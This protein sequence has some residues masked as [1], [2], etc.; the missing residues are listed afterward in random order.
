MR[1]YACIDLK[2]FY[3]SVECVER[4]WDPL[5]A[6]V[7][8]AD[9]ARTD[10][11]ICLAVS[12]ALKAY[13]ISSRARLF[14]AKQAVARANAARSV[15]APH[16]KLIG[17]ALD[18]GMLAADS[19][20]AIGFLAAPPRMALYMDYSTRV[21]DVYLRYMAPEDLHVYSVDEV[22]AD[23]TPYLKASGDSPEAMVSRMV[24]DV[25]RTT[26]IPAAAGIGTN[27]YLAKVAMD[28]LA[29]HTAPDAHGVR[30]A[31]LTEEEYRRRLWTH[32]PIT[33]FW[34]VGH[35]YAR[36][37]AEYRLYTMGDVARCSFRHEDLLHRLFGVNA[38]LLIDHAWG[39]EPC[40]LADVK[41]YRPTVNSLT[42]G[43]VLSRPYTTAEARLVLREMTEAMALD[44]VSK[45][46]LTDQTVLQIGYDAENISDPTRCGYYRGEVSVDAYGRRIPRSAHGTTH[47]AL[48][49]SARELCEA[50]L[51]LYDKIVQP[52]LTVRR[53]NLTASRVVCE[54][55][56][57]TVPE[58][59]TLFEDVSAAREARRLQRHRERAMQ[60]ALLWIKG[61]YGNN[62]VFKGM[63]LL[64]GATARERNRQIGGHKA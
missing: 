60:E 2:S 41:A 26:G 39:I 16:G 47:M 31:R 59:L 36:R 63:D 58:Q 24:R 34:R 55:E 42:S 49:S 7:L 13:G 33:D 22:F 25:Q 10:K 15:R 5:T 12:P 52:G 64:D 35:G 9:E 23:L 57:P 8:V 27:L 38:E 37:L 45:G 30:I 46:L 17:E 40:T 21:Y 62:A 54:A 53:L 19:S 4:G 32:R 11:T 20:A 51:A 50:V 56:M 43:Q 6:H 61:K 48:T 18:A 1:W 28:V 44:L 14:E 29:K 3:A